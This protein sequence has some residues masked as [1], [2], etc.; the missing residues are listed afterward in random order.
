MLARL[1]EEKI[2]LHSRI[3]NTMNKTNKKE[4]TS[5]LTISDLCQTLG[6]DEQYLLKYI[7]RK[8]NYLSFSI[9]KRNGSTRI[10]RAPKPPLKTVQKNLKTELEKFYTPKSSTHGFVPEK[11]VKTNAAGH[12]G[13]KYV[14]NIDLKDFFET[15]HFGRIKNLFMKAPFS[16]PENVATVMAHMCCYNGRLAQGAPTSPLISNMICRKLDSQ[17]QALASKKK[18]HYSRYADDITFSFT[19]SKKYLPSEILTVS[20]DGFVFV[21]KELEQLVSANG[22]SINP[23]KTRL[24]SANQRQLVTGL[25]VNDFVNLRRAFIRKTGS[26]IYIL[27]K[28]GP[29]AAESRYLE[30]IGKN[31]APLAS[32]QKKRTK[33]K[34]G[35]FFIKVLLG[36]INYIQMV[37]GRNDRIYRNLAYKLS[38]ALG[39]ENKEFLKSPEEILGN[40]V[41]IANNILSD[42]QGTAF[43][44]RG[45]GIVTNQH[46][47]DGVEFDTARHCITFKKSGSGEEL[48][49]DLIFSDKKLDI[50]IFHP[51]PSFDA[52][53]C[54]ETSKS[55]SVKPMDSVLSIGFPKHVE[56]AGCYI[57]TGKTTQLRRN[58]S[59]D[60]WCI[61]TVLMEG[62]SGGPIFDSSMEVIGIAARGSSGNASNG[63]IYGFIPITEISHILINKKYLRR[64][65]FLACLDKKL[66]LSTRTSH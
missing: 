19:C 5:F 6:A 38:V 45:V 9:R 18:C 17:L 34:P 8:S 54:L 53:P 12:T 22:F 57:T 66:T 44:L 39:K 52:T 56:G 35:D 28:F 3:P 50:A 64:K 13:K 26:M 49:A 48:S 63:Y 65:N 40:S 10:I 32:R 47:I 61:D 59:F 41:F 58:I 25:V 60:M 46:V 37:K 14:F 33:T 62:N 15:I 27:K 1:V 2:V 29:E 31:K 16:A 21:G 43:L 20:E 24:Q 11:S 42:S 36:R 55:K 4:D 30:L 23:E 7:Y 51:N